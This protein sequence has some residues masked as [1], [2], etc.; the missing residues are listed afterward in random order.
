VI[1]VVQT[2]LAALEVEAVLRPVSAEWTSITPAMRRLELA[3]GEALV[4]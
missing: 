4:S 2:D 3:A 1:R